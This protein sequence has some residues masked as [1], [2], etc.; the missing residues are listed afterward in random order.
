MERVYAVRSAAHRLAALS[1]RVH[2][3]ATRRTDERPGESGRGARIALVHALRASMAPAE[4]AFV[5]GWP[6]ARIVHLL[7][8]SLP[9]DLA[10]AGGLDEHMMGRF[11][12]LGRYCAR[13]GAAAVLFTCS[14]FGSAIARVREDLHVPVL[15]PN[16]AMLEEAVACGAPVALLATFE[17]TITS[18]LPEFA[19][20]AGRQGGVCDVVGSAV[21][22]ALEAL[23][24][25]DG[26]AHDVLVA[27]AA[28]AVDSHRVVALAQ[29]S[30]ARAAPAVER[31][32]GRRVL[33][34]PDAA[35]AKLRRLVQ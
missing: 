25:G 21:A 30:M 33:T 22:G 1:C 17:A 34:T 29:F 32:T 2:D 18:M 6:E 13:S 4:E 15:S 35:V 8:D 23:Q 31:V 28:A 27:A 20:E 9:V 7:D 16:E 24:R 5:R 14:A 10:A 12:A 19:A 3:E 11:V 26:A